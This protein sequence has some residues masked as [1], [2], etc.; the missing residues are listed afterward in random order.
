MACGDSTVIPKISNPEKIFAIPDDIRNYL[1]C[2]YGISQRAIMFLYPPSP[3]KIFIAENGILRT[4]VI[5][6]QFSQSEN[7]LLSWW[8]KT[9]KNIER[10]NELDKATAVTAPSKKSNTASNSAWHTLTDVERHIL[11]KV[12]FLKY[13]EHRR[14]EAYKTALCQAYKT[15]GTCEYGDR[16]RFAHSKEELRLPPQ[17]HPKYKT[18]LCRK[19]AILGMCPYGARCQFIHQ[20]PFENGDTVV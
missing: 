7:S 4:I 12:F 2:N 16:C 1:I 3:N 5:K 13:L 9:E 17:A 11:Q 10:L 6:K 8:E 15:T 14:A 18:Q 19:F 20:R